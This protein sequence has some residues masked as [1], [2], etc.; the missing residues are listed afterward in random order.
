M[1][2]IPEDFWEKSEYSKRV[3]EAEPITTDLVSLAESKLGYKLP[4]GYVE[5]MRIQNGGVPNRTC[6]RTIQ[7]TSWSDNHIALIGIYGISMSKPNS[8]CGEFRTE[9]WVQ[10]W[11]YPPIGVYFADCPSAGHDML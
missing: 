6:F 4:V 9:F 7:R 5:L 8:L 3:Y 10:E 1:R 2:K 11:G